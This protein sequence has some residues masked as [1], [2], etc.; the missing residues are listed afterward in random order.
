MTLLA[1]ADVDEE[2]TVNQVA[3]RIMQFIVIVT[4]FMIAPSIFVNA[5]AEDSRIQINFLS[6]DGVEKSVV[7]TGPEEGASDFERALENELSKGTSTKAVDLGAKVDGIAK[8]YDFQ[9]AELRRICN[10]DHCKQMRCDY[11]VVDQRECDLPL[12]GTA[13]AKLAFATPEECQIPI[14]QPCRLEVC[15]IGCFCA[16]SD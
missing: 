1:A 8:K 16:I 3:H 7:Y 9:I 5:I 10:A 12:C 13:R 14:P 11:G 4:A 15:L 6:D 2:K